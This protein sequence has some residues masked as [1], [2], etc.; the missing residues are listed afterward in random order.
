MSRYLSRKIHAAVVAQ[1]ARERRARQRCF[2]TRVERLEDR[3]LMAGGSVVLAAGLVTITPASTGPN[4]AIVSYQ[5]VS[6]TKMLDVSL[7]GSSH[8]FGVATVGFVYYEGSGVSGAQTF[9]NETGLHTVAWG[10]SGANLFVGTTGNDDFFGGSGTNTFDAG[11]GIDMLIGG[12]G[13]KRLQ[14]KRCRDGR[15]HRGRKQQHGQRSAGLDG[16]VLYR[17]SRSAR[18][19]QPRPM[20]SIHRRRLAPPKPGTC[21]QP[22]PAAAPECAPLRTTASNRARTPLLRGRAVCGRDAGE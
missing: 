8:Y 5:N 9:E 11:S 4:T 19:A 14:R 13:A 2:H 21:P 1:T 18:R 10:G 16:N 7:N 20:T 22:T 3:N 6:G 15:H 17:L 12:S